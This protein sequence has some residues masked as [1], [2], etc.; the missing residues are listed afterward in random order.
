M[1]IYFA[2]KTLHIL[3]VVLFVGNIIVTGWWKTMAD[4]TREPRIVAFAQR[5]VALTDW[6]FTF[7]GIVMVVIGG[8]GN[9]YWHGIPLS[10]PWLAL[11]QS[12][13]IIS[14]VVWVA[15]LVPLQIKLGRMARA[16][17]TAGGIPDAYWSL[18]RLWLWF[19]IVATILPLSVIP[20]MVLK[21]G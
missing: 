4:R 21:L 7:G 9:A 15:V 13:F 18:S 19:G 20:V 14:G 12:L 1:D 17:A 11:G 10:T 16:F 5:Q 3:G 8:W 2:L 6:V